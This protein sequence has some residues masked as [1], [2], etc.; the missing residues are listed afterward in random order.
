MNTFRPLLAGFAAL[1]SAAPVS[2]SPLP[3]TS[4]RSLESSVVAGDATDDGIGDVLSV[5]R[6]T[7][8]ATDAWFAV[9]RDGATGE[10]RYET[11]L[12]FSGAHPDE[13]DVELPNSP[14]DVRTSDQTIYQDVNADAIVDLIWFTGRIATENLQGPLT[15][16]WTTATYSIIDG[17][18]GAI[19][20]GEAEASRIANTFLPDVV[21][22]SS[23][24]EIRAVALAAGA[25]GT[26]ILVARL[27]YREAGTSAR[28]DWIDAGGAIDGSFTIEN[29]T[30]RYHTFLAPGD[31]DGD[32]LVDV[33]AAAED[34]DHERILRA[35]THD[36]DL[37]WTNDVIGNPHLS[38]VV[39]LD[40]GTGLD[41]VVGEYQA[42]DGA[43][44]EP[45]W[46]DT[47]SLV[48]DV[49]GDGRFDRA[50]A[51]EANGLKMTIRSGSSNEVLV[52]RTYPMELEWFEA[53][54][55]GDV[56]PTG[57]SALDL[58]R[59]GDVSVTG[60]HDVGDLDGDGTR[61]ISLSAHD[62]DSFVHET[63]FVSGRTF[64]E[65]RHMAPTESS[66]FTGLGA[67]ADGDGADDLARFGGR[68]A[69]WIKIFR[70]TQR[71]PQMRVPVIESPAET[72]L[73]AA[74]GAPADARLLLQAGG[75]I[76][77]MADGAGRILWR[78]DFAD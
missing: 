78:V 27:V 42:F 2:A 59:G 11:T 76:L 73:V 7:T 29:L 52:E 75:H 66:R 37:L 39:Q 65:L 5:E 20:S 54:A 19:W 28:I 44:G 31:L 67:D 56:L 18:T 51:E 62:G 55:H 8:I 34:T 30:G 9:L 69:T 43:T 17:A 32:G 16:T 72:P 41:L 22:L 6:E 3:R 10:A 58:E 45:L 68:S 24:E 23:G 46:E 49:D 60:A 33:I 50:D 61:D 15:R 14:K 35:F 21:P 4:T 40:G 63:M 64:A 38:R 70:A 74:A 25:S 13:G 77:A 26:Q 1:L 12:P 57:T 53:W 36:G 47:T 48:E 71:R